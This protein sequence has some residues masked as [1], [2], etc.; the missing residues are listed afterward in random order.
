M[1]VTLITNIVNKVLAKLKESPKGLKLMIPVLI[2][3]LALALMYMMVISCG[4]TKAVVKQPRQGS[5]TTISVT[6]S[7]P[8]SISTE[9]PIN[10][11]V[12]S[13]SVSQKKDTLLF[14]NTN[15]LNN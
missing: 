5:T 1:N 2:S 14:P 9:V 4:T 6:T 10:L 12:S 13:P 7:N 8:T 11:K 15:H 3:L